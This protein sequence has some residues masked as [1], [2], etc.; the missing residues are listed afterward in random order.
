MMVSLSEEEIRRLLEEERT[1]LQQIRMSLATDA[2]EPA[3]DE[4]M[5][6]LSSADQ[7]DAD[8]GTETFE[9]ERDL[10]ILDHVDSQLADV[11]RAVERLRQGT[12]G[13]CE[14]CGRPIDEDRLRARP[15][16]RFCIDDQAKAERGVP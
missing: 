6:E 13:T 16:A 10:S 15:A 11:E 5:G 4:V 9:R 14:A 2:G 8:L 3:S 7:H 1:R 12:Y